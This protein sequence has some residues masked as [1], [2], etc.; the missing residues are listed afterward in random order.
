MTRA[1]SSTSTTRWYIDSR[2][3]F[4][5]T[6]NEEL[7]MDGTLHDTHELQIELADGSTIG[8]SK[9]GTVKGIFTT[10][11]GDYNVM[12][13]D[14]LIVPKMDIS[15]ISAIAIQENGYSIIFKNNSC[16]I[17]RDADGAC[18][19]R[20][21]RIGRSY[22]VEMIKNSTAFTTHVD[23]PATKNTWHNRLGHLGQKVVDALMLCELIKVPKTPTDD[24]H[25]CTA[26][27]EG[28]MT[29]RHFGP[30]LKPR[31]TRKLD[32]VHSD[33]CGPMSCN[34]FGGYRY[35]MELVDDATRMTFASFLKKKSEALREFKMFVTDMMNQGHGQVRTLSTDNGTEYYHKEFKKYLCLSGIEHRTSA[36]YTPEQNGLAE[37]TNRTLI[38]K[39]RCMMAHA[40][41]PQRYCMEQ[42]DGY[43]DDQHSEFVCKLNKTVYG[44]KQPPLTWYNTI[45]P[46]LE[47]VGVTS[48]PSDSGVFL[49][50]IEDEDV[51]LAIYADDLFIACT[52]IDVLNNIKSTFFRLEGLGND[53]TLSRHR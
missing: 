40:K 2:A 17:I 12:L 23:I 10:S 5:A 30:V 20:T 18:A 16:E 4:H 37:R 26:C 42:P 22:K 52:S 24:K 48:S 32:L 47:A 34:S 38:E 21:G 53:S 45:R 33:L 7:F 1:N 25:D 8:A 36:P 39:G 27:M 19:L 6:N 11:T 51:L 15:L 43:V 41:L 28:K 29:R 35:D 44:L 46:V 9:K 31:S 3:S 50:N 13:L 49:G 14:V